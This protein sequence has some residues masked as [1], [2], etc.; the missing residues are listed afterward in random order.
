MI[1]TTLALSAALLAMTATASADQV[2]RRAGEWEIKMQ[3]GPMGQMTQKVC[4]STDKSAADLSEMKGRMKE[5]ADPSVNAS[6]NTVTVDVTCTPQPG[7]KV[8]IHA[9]VTTAGPDA[10][11]TETH[12]KMEGGPQGMPPEMT[13]VS[14]ARRI[15]ACQPSDFKAD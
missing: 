15:G 5:C 2:M 3:N 14:D 6:G 1:R 12:M 13:M 7:G 10:F 9:V 8:T 4:F 11:H